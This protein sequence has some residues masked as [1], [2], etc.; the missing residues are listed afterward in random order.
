MRGR[1]ELRPALCVEDCAALALAC[2]VEPPVVAGAGADAGRLGAGAGLA[3]AAGAA[4][5]E[6]DGAAGGLVVDRGC[7]GAAGAVGA[8]GGGVL[9]SWTG[10]RGG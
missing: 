6:A 2:H 9:G 3:G 7:A 10:R 8:G 1:A 4:C 5:V